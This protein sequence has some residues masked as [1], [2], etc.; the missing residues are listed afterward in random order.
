MNKCSAFSHNG[1]VMYTSD[2]IGVAISLNGVVLRK[3]DGATVKRDGQ[4]QYYVR[5]KGAATKKSF[6]GIFLSIFLPDTN[7]GR[8]VKL[9][10]VDI[11]LE[12]LYT[13]SNLVVMAN[14]SKRVLHS[15]TDLLQGVILPKVNYSSEIEHLPPTTSEQLFY[16]S[17]GGEVF[18]TEDGAKFPTKDL[19]DWHQDKVSK[20]KGNAQIVLDYNGGWVLAE[21]IY[22]QEVVYNSGKPYENFCDVMQNH[23]GVVLSEELFEFD[24]GLI[25]QACHGNI[26]ILGLGLSNKQFNQKKASEVNKLLNAYIDGHKKQVEAFDRLL[27]SVS[28]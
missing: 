18:C 27:D 6:L 13:P 9:G 28:S 12:E 20:G 22:L 10:F 3:K 14:N 11:G 26:V 25:Q 17:A 1:L 21:E 19:A 8:G 5:H 7:F 23:L 24:I 4:N 15:L 16:K 2:D